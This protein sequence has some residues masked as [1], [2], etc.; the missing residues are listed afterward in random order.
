MARIR[1]IKPEF[2]T[3]ERVVECSTNARL[4]FVGTWNFCDDKGRH[5]YSAK[6]LKMCIFPGDDD[7][8]TADV[9]ALMGELVRVG[10]IVRYCVNGEQYFV[11]SGWDHQKI[12]KPQPT[13]WPGPEESVIDCECH[14]F[15]ELSAN[16]RRIIG[17][18]S[19]LIG[20]DRIGKDRKGEE[21]ILPAAKASAPRFKPPTLEEVEAYC[22]ER[23]Q[24]VS[25]QR[26]YDHYTA[27]GWKVGRNTMKDWRASVRGWERSDF[28][29]P[30]SHIRASKPSFDPIE[31][32]KQLD[33]QK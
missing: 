32:L 17:E 13:R 5:P 24:G 15:D 29:T 14:P 27:N 21:G 30:I 28:Q 31:K 16:D 8:T 20:E 7:I 22:L 1:S 11:V 19:V 23:N 10:L 33:S 12:D 6:R 9:E 25:A 2:W 3:S 18:R 4:L 26:W